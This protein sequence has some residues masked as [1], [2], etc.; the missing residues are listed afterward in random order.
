MSDFNDSIIYL[1]NSKLDDA[2]PPMFTN[3]L[4][5]SKGKTP[6][7][8]SGFEYISNFSFKHMICGEEK[9]VIDDQEIAITDGESLTIN[10]KTDTTFL[11]EDG[12][13]ISIFID[14]SI[15]YDIHRV[16]EN[17]ERAI[18]YPFEDNPEVIRLYDSP[19]KIKS[20]KL[21][22]LVDVVLGESNPVITIDFYYEF[23]LELLTIHNSMFSKI[24]RL[25]ATKLATRKELYRR[26]EI[27]RDFMRSNLSRSFNLDELSRVSCISKF[28]LIR[29]FKEVFD[30]TP[31]KYFINAKV[32]AAKEYYL[33][34]N[35][36]DS[37]ENLAHTF[38]YPDS[39]TFSKQF[40]SVLGY[41]PSDLKVKKTG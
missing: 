37:I 19:S 28:H 27:A 16:L 21:N 3:N 40:K 5:T 34:N 29:I 17:E 41:S 25:S 10:D 26:I 18:E 24:N 11:Y 1:D 14:P 32:K 39:A 35:C 4:F 31:H 13:A 30:T 9:F 20:P 2:F 38:G 33:K 6:D 22:K 8:Y 15:I 23:A 7:N 36:E 12:K